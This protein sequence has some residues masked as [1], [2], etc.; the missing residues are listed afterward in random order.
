MKSLETLLDT[1]RELKQSDQSRLRICACDQSK[2]IVLRSRVCGRH[3]LVD[4]TGMKR[5]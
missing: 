4:A 1:L 3:E 5:E 2:T